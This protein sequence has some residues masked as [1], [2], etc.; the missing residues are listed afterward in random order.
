MSWNHRILAHEF[1]DGTIELHIHEVY[2]DKHGVP[3]G[4]TKNP[5]SIGAEDI[6]G[7][8]WQLE[9]IKECLEKPIIYFGDKFPQ[10]YKK[11]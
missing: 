4:C 8:N 9:K 10:E 2:Y 5:I 6:D 1:P 3:D 7:M 11:E